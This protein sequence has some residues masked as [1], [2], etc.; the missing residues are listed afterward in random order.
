MTK[1]TD[2]N[3]IEQAE[4]VPVMKTPAGRQTRKG[5]K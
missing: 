4:E 2:E 5:K 3:G 1:I